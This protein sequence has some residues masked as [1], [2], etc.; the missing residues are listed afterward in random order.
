MARLRRWALPLAPMQ[1]ITTSAMR[2]NLTEL[3]ALRTLAPDG[4]LL[5][6][7]RL[8]RMFAF[9]FLSVVLGLYLAALDL[10]DQQIGVWLT[11]ML[12][13]DA[14]L[15]L[16]MATMADRLGRQRMLVAGAWLM[17]FG[18]LVFGLA[19]NL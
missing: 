17:I 5:I 18:G 7:T 15:S 6:V 8:V 13:G 2:L 12:V 9:G 10:T 19:S 3:Q 11:L 1:R 14:V 4:R 16:A